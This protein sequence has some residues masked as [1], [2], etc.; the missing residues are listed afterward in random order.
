MLFIF[1]S[2][3]FLTCLLAG[4][5]SLCVRY[6]R[7]ETDNPCLYPFLGMFL[8]GTMF[9]AYSLFLPLQGISMV[10]FV[11]VG[12]IGLPKW[13][14]AFRTR[15]SEYSRE[16]CGAFLVFMLSCILMLSARYSYS[17]WPGW[18]FDTD[19]YH[20]NTVLWLNEYGTP[21]GLANL[22]T[23]LGFNSVWLTLSALF[24]N[25]FWDNRIAWIMPVLLF[26]CTISY[27][28]YIVL[29]KSGRIVRLFCGT[30][31]FFVFYMNIRSSAPSLYYDFP[32]LF[33][34]MA[35]FVECLALA[36]DGWDIT[37]GQAS[38]I[39]CLAVLA[40]T[41]KPLAG[42]SVFFA[43]GV[44]I[45]GLKK[46]RCLSAAHICVAFAPAVASGILWMARNC[47]LSGYPLFPLYL[48]PLSADWT[49]PTGM[50][51]GTYEDII[52]W[53]RTPGLPGYRQS[54]HNWNWIV[55]W[56]KRLIGSRDFW[57]L[58]GLPLLAAIPLWFRALCRRESGQSAFFGA[59]AALCLLYWFVTAPDLRFGVIFFQIFF[60]VGLAFAFNQTMWLSAWGS[61]CAK[62]LKNGWS[63]IA[64]SAISLLMAI[65]VSAEALHSSKRNIFHVGSIPARELASRT[66]DTSV[67]PPLL[68]FFPVEGNRCGNSPIPCTPYDNLGLRLRVPGDLGSGFYI[69]NIER[70]K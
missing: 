51:V 70:P 28:L 67:S 45:Y 64:I 60:A 59:W 15:R 13:R 5:G 21:P 38:L 2:V 7:L 32:A 6:I 69:D 53:A 49:V 54:L 12:L 62:F 43:T 36:E 17:V 68:L 24:D 23:R 11:V 39:T 46:T 20:A 30:M 63:Y 10:V 50:V 19:L 31:L 9:T 3:I 27:L 22:H 37:T 57:L 40:F 61:N 58:T 29:F 66:L 4:W 42:I 16:A 34:N 48:F 47:L 1:S 56:M 65:L 52:A 18:A 26:S 41:I 44:A 14:D 33:I 8:A 55:P 35:V 25:G